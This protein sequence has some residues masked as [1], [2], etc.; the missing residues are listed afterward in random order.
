VEFVASLVRHDPGLVQLWWPEW[1]I[2]GYDWGVNPDHLVVIDTGEASALILVEVDES[3]ERPP[4]IRDRLRA[5]A[6]LFED[7]RVGWHLL[8]V[9]NSPERLARLRQIAGPTKLPML[10]GRCWGVAIDDI[11]D[12]GADAEVLAI[13][14]KD[15]SRPLRSIATDPKSRPSD[16]EVGS[17][18]WITLIA[19]GAIE[20]IGPFWHGVERV[21]AEPVPVA[22]VVDPVVEEASEPPAVDEGPTAMDSPEAELPA[23]LSPAA[24]VPASGLEDMASLDL[25][26]LI[27]ARHRTVR[28][29]LKAASLLAARRDWPDLERSVNMLCRSYEPAEQLL[30]LH[31]IRRYQAIDLDMRPALLWLVRSLAREADGRVADRAQRLLGTMDS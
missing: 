30:G 10:S 9:A 20:D 31:I 27:T 1:L 3:T 25:A 28:Q 11:S 26:V 2:P 13:G 16:Y 7:H 24:V 15:A 14:A 19:N 18:A 22:T 21:Q 6:K 17:A 5:Y 23:P 29:A 4:V 8:W 12:R